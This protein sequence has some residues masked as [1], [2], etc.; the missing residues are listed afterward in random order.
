MK[1]YA[2]RVVRRN[3]ETIVEKNSMEELVR[4]F[5]YTLEAGKSWEHERGN[6][7]INTNPKS[8][9]SLITNLNKA[10][11]NTSRNGYS[12]TYYMEA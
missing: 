2:V 10:S 6:S 11:A 12:S 4:Y 7:K 3:T 1:R 5:S 8:V 9:K